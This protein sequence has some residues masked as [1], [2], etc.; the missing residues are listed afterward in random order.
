MIL[1]DNPNNSKQESSFEQV[2]FVLILLI[3]WEQFFYFLA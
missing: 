1:N 3:T 2:S